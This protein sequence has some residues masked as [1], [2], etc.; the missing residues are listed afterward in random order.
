MILPVILKQSLDGYIREDEE[1]SVRS[2][3]YKDF[4]KIALSFRHW[5]IRSANG[6]LSFDSASLFVEP[7]LRVMCKTY[8]KHYYHLLI[9]R[10]FQI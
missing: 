8:K 1:F 6:E 9:G 10:K 5:T 4:C 3:G 2:T 7:F